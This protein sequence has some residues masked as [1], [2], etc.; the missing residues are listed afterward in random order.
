[1]R[2]MPRPTRWRSAAILAATLPI[3]TAGVS[4][5]NTV[6]DSVVLDV[7]AGAVA[8][9]MAT[10]PKCTAWSEVGG[11]TITASGACHTQGIARYEDRTVTSCQDTDADQGILNFLFLPVDDYAQPGAWAEPLTERP[12][13]L[14]GDHDHAAVGQALATLDGKTE[15]VLIPVVASSTPET[16]ARVT[17]FD[18]VG[19]S[20]CAFDHQAATEDDQHLGA[21]ALFSVADQVFMAACSWDCDWLYVYQLDPSREDCA[22]TQLSANAVACDDGL[23]T[24]SPDMK[25]PD[26]NWGAYNSL[27]VFQVESQ[28]PTD[29][30]LVAGHHGWLDTWQVIG[31]TGT[32]PRFEKVAKAAWGLAPGEPFFGRE[33][34][35]EGMT[36]QQVDADSIDVWTNPH[37]V[38]ACGGGRECARA[39]YQCRMD[40]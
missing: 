34:L 12:A 28:S 9:T 2:A 6:Y 30:Y 24:P 7:S 17:L 18:G 21:V 1:M 11:A 22:P 14:V 13:D 29:V 20:V 31:A 37:D 36:I 39:L 40:F 8:T 35:Y 33:M 25:D 15:G 19:G 26:A 5:C 38:G 27:A 4:E 10:V 23:R 3:A 32:G 16:A